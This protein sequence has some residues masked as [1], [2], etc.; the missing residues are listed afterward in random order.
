MTWP[1]EKSEDEKLGD[2]IRSGELK[3]SQPRTNPPNF[4]K[5]GMKVKQLSVTESR[6][7]TKDRLK[8]LKEKLEKEK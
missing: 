3:I 1:W 2:R 6:K 7:V 4:A 5:F 8:D